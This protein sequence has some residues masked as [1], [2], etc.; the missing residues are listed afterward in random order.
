MTLDT[1]FA[2]C[3]IL[4][5]ALT[6]MQPIL[7]HSIRLFVPLRWMALALIAC[8]ALIVCRDA[9]FGVKPPSGWS[10]SGS[11]QPVQHQNS[12]EIG[13]ALRTLANR[14]D[15]MRPTGTFHR[16]IVASLCR[17]VFHASQWRAFQQ[18]SVF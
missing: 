14:R 9:P 18:S 1:V 15:M 12:Q 8:F 16:G 6:I 13:V 5:A 4:V 3:A 11:N 2:I 7:R 17:R 10:P